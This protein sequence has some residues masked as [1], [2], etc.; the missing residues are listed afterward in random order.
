VKTATAT[1]GADFLPLDTTAEVETPEHVRFQHHLAGPVRRTA[2]YLLD[3][4]V[5]GVILLAVGM[6]LAILGTV[7]EESLSGFSM[8][9]MLLVYFL[10][11]WFYFVLFETIWSGRTPGK[12]ALGIRVVKEGGHSLQT[13]DALLRNL[14]RAADFLPL[15]Y[16]LGV[17][18]MGR[19]PKFRRLGDM[20]AGTVVV[21]E[22]RSQIGAPLQI[23]PTPTAEELGA[24][25]PRPPLSPDEIETLELFLRRRGTLAP[26]REIELAELVA[27]TLAKRMGARYKDPS[28]FLALVYY[29]ARGGQ[30]KA[31]AKP[32]WGQPY[33]QEDAGEV[34]A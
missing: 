27:P 18:V 30:P 24:L 21:V 10:L 20:V 23:Q 32:A 25:P 22:D 6:V 11:D 9:A 12:R 2:A 7:G 28:R 33:R 26:V 13:V 29:K 8:G 4:L 15:G 17:A 19:D 14:L 1:A 31:H 34:R 16:A 5:R 3:A